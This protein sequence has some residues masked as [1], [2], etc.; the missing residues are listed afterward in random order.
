MC[1]SQECSATLR[2]EVD[3]DAGGARL[4]FRKRRIGGLPSPG[5]CNA[6]IGRHFRED[7]DRDVALA[8]LDA[9]RSTW[10]GLEYVRY[11]EL[12]RHERRIDKETEH[13]FGLGLDK[14]LGSTTAP[15][16]LIASSPCSSV[17]VQPRP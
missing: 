12:L 4:Q 9:E 2:V 13:G 14:D 3:C 1:E 10:P 11:P 17:L 5:E 8:D 16:L 6:A 15:S 7:P